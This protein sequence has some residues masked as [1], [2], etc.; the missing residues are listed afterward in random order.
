M[1]L[2][3]YSNTLSIVVAKPAQNGPSDASRIQRVPEMEEKFSKIPVH[4]AD[5]IFFKI[6]TRTCGSGSVL[7]CKIAATIHLRA[8]SLINTPEVLVDLI[9]NAALRGSG[10]SGDLGR[11]GFRARVRR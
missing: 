8:G 4:A 3:T 1:G 6:E 9:K 5:D 11:C 2:V 7:P 10:R